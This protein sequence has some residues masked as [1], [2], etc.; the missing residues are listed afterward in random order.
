MM[1]N[2]AAP[3][4]SKLIP[5]PKPPWS[6][7]PDW[8]VFDA[9]VL[10]V[11]VIVPP[12]PG[13]NEIPP[14]K[15]PP[16]GPVSAAMF[17]ANELFVTVSAAL[18]E[19]SI[20]TPPPKPRGAVVLF[21]RTSLLMVRLDPV[22]STAPPN[23]CCEPPVMDIPESVAVA[24]TMSK[25]RSPLPTIF[26]PAAPEPAPAM[27]TLAVRFRSPVDAS[28]GPLGPMLNVYVP[29]GR[30]IVLFPAAALEAMTAERRLGQVTGPDPAQGAVP[31]AVPVTLNTA[32][33]A[34]DTR[35]GPP[36]TAR[37]TAPPR[38]H[39]RELRSTLRPT[40]ASRSPVAS[41]TRDSL[42]R[43]VSSDSNFDAARRARTIIQGARASEDRPTIQAGRRLGLPGATAA[44]NH[45]PAGWLLASVRPT[46]MPPM[47]APRPAS[48]LRL[49]AP[50]ALVLMILALPG[51]AAA[52]AQTTYQV[53]FDSTRVNQFA[54]M[55]NGPSGSE[56]TEVV[57]TID[58]SAQAG[59]AYSGSAMSTYKQ[60]SGMI[61]ES[62]Q[63]GSTTGTTTETE[64][65]GTPPTF[66]AT[67]TPGSGNSGGSLVLDLGSFTGGR[68]RASRTSQAAAGSQS[69]TRRLSSW[70]IS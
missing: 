14:P 51:Q 13:S 53:T 5:P 33:L 47:L 67:Y 43:A 27:V 60:A 57:A 59:G 40:T 23:C 31:S 2:V 32:A 49:V 25:T 34:P 8:A 50:V 21:V 62:C 38:N 35:P 4:G 15:P 68:R 45:R 46:T 1:V 42:V 11:T 61:S 52:A 6:C 41:S 7:V 24:A 17:E 19:G 3:L 28:S 54:G 30:L 22:S 69:A 26:V 36:R 29:A 65:S 48:A 9:K 55:N 39:R 64:L 70:R 10:L 12:P 66:T 16:L 58:L 37:A 20:D 18:P 56:T 44:C 63:S